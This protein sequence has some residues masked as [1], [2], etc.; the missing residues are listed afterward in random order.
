MRV[1]AGVRAG[2]W[3]GWPMAASWVG[4]G[5]PVLPLPPKPEPQP[6]LYAPLQQLV[7]AALAASTP[8]MAGHL[9]AVLCE[10]HAAKRMGAV[11]SAD[12][13]LTRL[14]EPLL[15]RALSAA[16]PAVRRN[17]LDLL[18][19]AF[20][21][22]VSGQLGVS[23]DGNRFWTTPLIKTGVG[24]APASSELVHPGDGWLH[25]GQPAGHSTRVPWHRK[26]EVHTPWC[27]TRPDAMCGTQ[28]M[29]PSPLPPASSAN[30]HALPA[31]PATRTPSA[32]LR[33][34]TCSCSASLPRSPTSWETMRPRCAQRRRR[35]SAA[36]STCFGRSSPPPPLR[37]MWR[38]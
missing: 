22:V 36:C 8:A 28:P 10:L 18:V 33:R 13:M 20:P 24:L 4:G 23:S 34:R 9:R 7:A 27:C 29:A 17:A 21:L 25:S 12:A 14:Y 5:G 35:A 38:A 37:C 6:Q 19:D 3:S 16:N 30:P 11:G 1:A 26:A 31:L 15:W 32:R 2:R